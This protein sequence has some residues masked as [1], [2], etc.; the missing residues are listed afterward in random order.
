M[1]IH[2]ANI[3]EYQQ[4]LRGYDY[5]GKIPVVIDFMLHGAVRAKC[6]LLI[7]S[8]WQKNMKGV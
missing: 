5:T 3:K 7:W 4:Y 2:V 8:V 6:L 1:I